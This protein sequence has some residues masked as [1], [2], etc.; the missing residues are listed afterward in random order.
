MYPVFEELAPGL[1]DK[2]IAIQGFGN[3]GYYAAKF[4]S[5]EDGCKVVGIGE[6]DCALYNPKGIPI[7]ELN[8][9]R[10]ENGSIKNFPGAETLPA[11]DSIWDVACDIFI[12]AA[13]ENQIQ[14]FFAEGD[15]FRF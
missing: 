5:E 1:T 10:K 14:I 9:F 7:E 6:W 13:L 15:R 8:N 11:A 2:T 4:L 12:P 3:V